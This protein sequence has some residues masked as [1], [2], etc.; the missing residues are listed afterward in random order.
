MTIKSSRVFTWHVALFL[1]FIPLF[2]INIH[3]S[4][5]WGDDFAQYITQAKNIVEGIPQSQ[6][7]YIYNETCRQLAPPAYPIGFPL[8]L[9]PVYVLFGVDFIAFNYLLTFFLVL[10]GFVFF[11]FFSKRFSLRNS[12]LLTLILIYNPWMLNFKMEVMADIPFVFFLFLGWLLYPKSNK[13]WQIILTGLVFGFAIAIKTVGTVALV[14]LITESYLLARKAVKTENRKIKFFSAIRNPF[15]VSLVAVSLHIILNII[16]F[17][18][19]GDGLSGYIAIL[20]LPALPKVILEGIGFY[21]Y[22]FQSFFNN[23]NGVVWVLPV[24]IHALVFCALLFG[25]I[26]HFSKKPFIAD[27]WLVLFYYIILLLFPAHTTGFRYLLP[28]AP[29]LLVYAAEGVNTVQ[30]NLSLTRSKLALILGIVVLASYIYPSVEIIS[31]QSEVLEGPMDKESSEALR[32]VLFNTP[33]NAVIAFCKPRV[34][35][36]FTGHPALTN[37]PGQPIREIDSIFK[38]KKVEYVLI[39]GKL[40]DDSLIYYIAWNQKKYRQVWNNHT[41]RYYKRK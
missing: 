5:D 23:E 17:R 33:G 13:T 6:T 9:V 20:N 34:L 29:F 31:K 40:S 19:P 16:I 8:L 18:L 7:G 11:A 30:L 15:I 37:R 25:I 38:L 10:L 28:V 24:A 41:F 1:L 27:D 12:L 36:L 3:S 4:H 2:F 32:Y 35:P 26:K 22:A 39:H 21:F 14:A